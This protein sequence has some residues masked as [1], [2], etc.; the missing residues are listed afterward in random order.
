MNVKTLAI[1]VISSLVLT[2]CGS[3]E[4]YTADFLYENADVRSQ[5]LEDCKAN[6]QSDEN[7][8]NA[9]EAEAKSQV[10]SLEDRM[11]K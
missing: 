4:S 7:C 10:K 8:K 9:N 11:N 3:T 1:A 6:K 5:V 2:A